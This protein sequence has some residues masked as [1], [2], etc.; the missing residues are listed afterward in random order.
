VKF[1]SFLGKVKDTTCIDNNKQKHLAEFYYYFNTGN[2]A[3]HFDTN[4]HEYDASQACSPTSEFVTKMFLQNILQM[5]FFMVLLF[6]LTSDQNLEETGNK[7]CIFSNND[8]MNN[9]W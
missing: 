6:H 8:K 4:G 5:D 1:L 2:T 9:Q 3:L 7:K